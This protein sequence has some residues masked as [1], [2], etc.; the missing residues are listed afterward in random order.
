MG[1]E[2]ILYR[3]AKKFLGRG[4]P[5]FRQV[6]LRYCNNALESLL[7]SKSTEQPVQEAEMSFFMDFTADST[8]SLFCG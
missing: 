1:W 3:V 8:L 2:G 6:V 4:Q 5:I 7:Q